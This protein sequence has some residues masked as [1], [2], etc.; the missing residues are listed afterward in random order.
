MMAIIGVYAYPGDELMGTSL[1]LEEID[2]F[3]F[4]FG[5]GNNANAHNS[6]NTVAIIPVNNPKTIPWRAGGRMQE[7]VEDKVEKGDTV[8]A[9]SVFEPDEYRR[10]LAVAMQRVWALQN[11]NFTLI[12]YTLKGNH[13]SAKRVILTPVQDKVR[14]YD[15]Q[16]KYGS[17]AR[18]QFR[19][20]EEYNIRQEDE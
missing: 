4:L 11:Y 1:K 9:P 16:I 3:V 7:V 18:L 19:K 8:Y 10:E 6:R 12:D 20:F 17:P 5:K 13:P 2:S 15:K 14:F